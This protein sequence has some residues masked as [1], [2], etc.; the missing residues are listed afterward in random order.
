MP[1][2]KG[3][4]LIVEDEVQVAAMLEAVVTALGYTTRAAATGTEAM[5]IMPE[6]RPDV[7]LLD[8]GLPDVR[9]EIMLDRLRTTDPRLPVVMVTGN[10]DAT[11]AR[12]T[13]AHGAFD[14]VVKP[15][16]MERLRE[17]L[18]AALAFRG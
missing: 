5:G 1:Q 16:H 9:G 3:R 4:V 12:S 14:Y 6:F 15:F 18:D 10:P 17:V 13:L 7:V 8:I 2:S 11:L